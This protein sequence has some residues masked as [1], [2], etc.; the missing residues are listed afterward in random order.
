MGAYTGT[1]LTSD[2]SPRTRAIGGWVLHHAAMTGTVHAL[3]NLM[4]PGG[5]TV[6]A[7]G[8]FKDGQRIQAVPH[9]RRA[10]S[11]ADA[12]WD[13]WALTCECVNSSGAPGWN[14]SEATHESIAQWIAVTSRDTGVW[15]HRDGNPKTWTVIG[16]REVYT[17][18]GGSYATACPGGMNL[19]WIVKRA[20]EILGGKGSTSAPAA[21]AYY[22]PGDITVG[23]SVA[24]VQRRLVAHGVSV[25][26]HGIDNQMGPNTIAGIYTFQQLKGLEKDGIVGPK[27][28]GELQK[29]P[30]GAKQPIPGVPAPAYPLPAGWYFGPKSGPRE[31]V[32]GYFSHRED[33][34][35][36]QQRMKDRGWIINPDGLYGPQTAGIAREFQSEK[37]LQVDALIGPET[38]RAAWEAPIT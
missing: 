15:P 14:L 26:P 18:H 34:R 10:W 27:T 29:A 33:L 32:S 25:G 31:S 24:D 37:S 1:R 6:S 13:S 11:L 28:W 30:A 20:Q 3:L 16:H 12:Y 9:N 7:H 35:R 17:I 22:A 21:P 23:V 36:W 4:M 19:G 5:R 2:H 38:W 8:A